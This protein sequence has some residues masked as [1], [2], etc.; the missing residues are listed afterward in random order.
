M[1]T[2]D[3][4]TAFRLTRLELQVTVTFMNHAVLSEL[5]LGHAVS[6]NDSNSLL[7]NSVCLYVCLL[8]L[9]LLICLY[10]CVCVCMYAVWQ[11]IQTE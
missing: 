1:D 10:V 8:V 2:N 6:V 7:A 4:I 5:F 11:Y 3:F 9:P